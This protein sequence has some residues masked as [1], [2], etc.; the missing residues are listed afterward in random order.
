M[1][2]KYFKQGPTMGRKMSNS[3]DETIISEDEIEELVEDTPVSK[4][5]NYTKP[6]APAADPAA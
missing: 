1:A 4:P 5:T 6:P 3:E 2:G